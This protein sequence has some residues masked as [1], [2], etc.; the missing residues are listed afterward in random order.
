MSIDETTAEPD[1]RIDPDTGN[2]II[3]W[4]RN[5]ETME[6]IVGSRPE[7]TDVWQRVPY[8]AADYGPV[9]DF[10]TDFDHADATYN[11]NAPRCGRQSARGVAPSLTPIDTAACGCR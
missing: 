11:P 8:D 2:K 6:F 4:D 5:G 10:A 9:V 3:T 1:I 7:G